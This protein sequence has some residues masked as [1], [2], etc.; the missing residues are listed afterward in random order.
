MGKL[1]LSKKE[2][3]RVE[4]MSKVEREGMTLQKAAELLGLSYRQVI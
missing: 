3:V 4:V 2:R 1:R